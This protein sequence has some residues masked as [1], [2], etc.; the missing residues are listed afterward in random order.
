[1]AKAGYSRRICCGGKP[2][3]APGL[4]ILCV[5]AAFTIMQAHSQLLVHGYLI[6]IEHTALIGCSM[7]QRA[8][9]CTSMVTTTEPC[10]CQVAGRLAIIKWHKKL[11]Q[12][13]AQA[14][15]D[16][17]WDINQPVSCMGYHSHVAIHRLGTLSHNSQ[18]ISGQ[19]AASYCYC[20]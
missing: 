11:Q 2:T 6:A 19:H 7:Q 12:V 15:S 18:H 20:C 17:R 10:A 5:P 3:G 4:L 14:V 16:Q 13:T 9:I 8:N 1:V